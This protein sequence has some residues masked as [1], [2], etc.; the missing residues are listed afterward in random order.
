[1]LCFLDIKKT[2]LWNLG[3]KLGVGEKELKKC[4]QSAET[5]TH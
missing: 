2:S 1:M 5:D 4:S 3:K